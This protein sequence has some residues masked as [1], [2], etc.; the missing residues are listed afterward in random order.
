LR[1]IDPLAVVGYGAVL[2]PALGLSFTGFQDGH[3]EAKAVTAF[4]KGQWDDLIPS[5]KPFNG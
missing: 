3:D 4:R 2:F 1:Q 5:M